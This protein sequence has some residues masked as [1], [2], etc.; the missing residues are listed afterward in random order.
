VCLVGLFH[1]RSLRCLKISLIHVS[2]NLGKTPLIQYF[3]LRDL[4]ITFNFILFLLLDR[5]SIENNPS[6][7]SPNWVESI[8]SLYSSKRISF[9][10][11]LGYW[12]S[13]LYLDTFA[14]LLALG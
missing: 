13:W 5:M 11:Y 12:I 9:S 14:W 2:C 3:V 10:V 6:I 8:R 1:V 4:I 7:L